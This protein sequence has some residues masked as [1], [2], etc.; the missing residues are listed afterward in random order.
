MDQGLRGFAHDGKVRVKEVE[1]SVYGR[2][3]VQTNF[4]KPSSRSL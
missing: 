3:D 4:G 2:A 1:L